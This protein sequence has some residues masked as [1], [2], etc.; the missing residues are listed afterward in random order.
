MYRDAGLTCLGCKY[1][2]LINDIER[3]L[4]VQVPVARRAVGL[5]VN[6]TTDT[7]WRV[8]K[9]SFVCEAFAASVSPLEAKRCS[10]ER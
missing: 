2:Q 5:G 7:K 8:G 4:H 9:K 10:F 1:R 3:L 6:A